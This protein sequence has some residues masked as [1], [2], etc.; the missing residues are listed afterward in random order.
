MTS[1]LRQPGP[2][3]PGHRPRGASPRRRSRRRRRRTW[4]RPL[5]YGIGGLIGLVLVVAVVSVVHALSIERRL[6]GLV[7]ALTLAQSEAESGH[8]GAARAELASAESTLASANATLYDSPDFQL[9]NLLPVGRQNLEA[10]R[11]G[12]S[13]GLQ[14]VIGGEQIFNAASPLETASGHLNIPLSAGQ[15]PVATLQRVATAIGGVLTTLPSSPLPP[16]GSLVLGPVRVELGK[17]YAQAAARRAELV[18]VGDSVNLINEI[19]GANGDRRYLIAVA[20]TAEMRGSGGMILSYGVLTSH[21]GKLTLGRF[22][23]I[24][25]LALTQPAKV[26]LP[27][28]FLAAYGGLAPTEQWREA[29]I[30]SDF[31]KVGPVL[32]AMYT[33]ATGLPVNGV[34]Q[35]DPAGL[36]AILAGTGPITV[37]A[38]GQ[39]TAANVVPLTLNQAY[40]DFPNRSVR[41]DYLQQVARAAFTQLVSG[42]YPSLRPL[43][44]ALLQA[45][46]A[47]HVLMYDTAGSAER[48]IAALG[49][50]GS[51]PG[52]G[53]DFAQLTLQN[54]GGDKMDY[55]L[56]SSLTITGRRPAN[57][58]AALTATID[59]H[60]TAPPN[61][62]P[63]YIFGPDNGDG[64]PPG[65]Y[66][67]L[68]TLYLPFGSYLQGSQTDQ[69]VGTKPVEGTQNQITAVTYSVIIPPGGSSHAVLQVLL[70]PRAPGP[71]H[72]VF[73]PTPRINPTRETANLVQ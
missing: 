60:D 8:L 33:Q 43:G 47:R 25:Q 62:Q 12:V 48:D 37:P 61:G 53:V 16:T 27:R 45:T 35:I 58:D 29:N 66:R 9:L 26:S 57:A 73:V 3:A 70:P 13:M 14:M 55:Y 46:A 38:L 44:T 15:I 54:F 32:D 71:E 40:V 52:P 64:D 63:P 30:M 28:D 19:A 36:G 49:F 11:A 67:G 2:R 21:A 5:L 69:T 6:G 4:L 72:F 7:P 31:T 41:Q 42:H 65:T 22:G 18:S 59:L 23:P 56:H 50:D 51:L 39:V 34:I 1:V 68:V 20:N 17:V 24:D 10:V